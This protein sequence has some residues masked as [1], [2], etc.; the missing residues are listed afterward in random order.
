MSE[1]TESGQSGFVD[2]KELARRVNKPAHTV[3]RWLRKRFPDR[4]G[5]WR[6]DAAEVEGLVAELSN[7]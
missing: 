1:P 4:E 7:S 5:W 2:L 6:F 3:R